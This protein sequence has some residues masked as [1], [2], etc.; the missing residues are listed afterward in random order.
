MIGNKGGRPKNTG[1]YEEAKA[2]IGLNNKAIVQRALTLALNKKSPNIVLLTKLLDKVLPTLTLGAMDI[3]AD[4]KT[5]LQ[6]IP[7]AAI[8]KLLKEFASY[9]KKRWG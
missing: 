3:D 4:V 8:K 7:D 6:R 2:L 1:G 9:D 5:D